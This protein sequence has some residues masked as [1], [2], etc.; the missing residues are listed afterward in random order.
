M[1][2][3]D[4]PIY[5]QTVY[6]FSP[7]AFLHCSSHHSTMIGKGAL[8]LLSIT[9]TLVTS[10]LAAV[11]WNAQPLNPPAFPL[12]VKS[13]YLS[14]WLPQGSGAALNDR[15][16]TFWTGATLGWCG[17]VRVDGVAYSW[18]GIPQTDVAYKKAVQK[19][20]KVFSFCY[21]GAIVSQFCLVHCHSNHFCA[22]CWPS[23]LDHQL[24]EPC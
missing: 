4:F 12:A 2:V 15:W 7:T 5:S 22:L 20:S 6:L 11:T 14:A 18:M 16:P 10:A 1:G 9:S 8:A 23:G 3:V 24:L 21:I 17:L 19:S 13:P